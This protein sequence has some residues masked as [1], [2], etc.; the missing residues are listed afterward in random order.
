[1]R[2]TQQSSFTRLE[3]TLHNLC[4]DCQA[5][6]FQLAESR[7]TD[8]E[9]LQLQTWYCRDCSYSDERLVITETAH[10]IR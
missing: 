7:S 1:M 8:H 2:N 5:P 9:D 10:S 6:E 3:T 4:P